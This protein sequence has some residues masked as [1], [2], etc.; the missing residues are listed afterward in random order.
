MATT[1]S[2]RRTEALQNYLNE[3]GADLK[4]DGIG[5]PK[6]LGVFDAVLTAFFPKVIAQPIEVS[7][8]TEVMP[9]GEMQLSKSGLDKVIGWECGGRGYYEKRLDFPTWPGYRS[10]VTI[11]IGYDCGYRSAH[12]IR[13]DWDQPGISGSELEALIHTSGVRGGSAKP[14]A[15]R[16]RWIDVPW[17]DAVR[18]FE[19]VTVPEFAKKTQ[20]AFPGVEN[21]HPD[22]QAMLFSLVYNRGGSMKGARRREMLVIR[23]LVESKDYRAMA[24]Q[25]RSMKR[26]WVGEGVDGLL[27]RRDEE[28]AVLNALAS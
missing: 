5:G 19:T 27:R 10:G 6:T 17:E 16:L 25:I 23:D 3:Q 28:A 7:S 22:A 1:L 13:Q 18:V 21:L 15:S 24:D 11:G 2:S 4:V 9:A 14:L 26:L 20:T 12:Q 8:P